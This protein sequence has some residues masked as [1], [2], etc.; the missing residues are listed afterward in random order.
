MLFCCSS[1]KLAQKLTFSLQIALTLTTKLL[2][3]TYLNR[4][5]SSN[6]SLGTGN[7]S[8][9]DGNVEIHSNE[10]SLV[11]NIN[12]IDGQL[13]ETHSQPSHTINNR[14]WNETELFTKRFFDKICPKKQW[15][16]RKNGPENDRTPKNPQKLISI[17]SFRWKLC[18]SHDKHVLHHW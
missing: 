4:W 18:F 16:A 9:L 17:T 8:I 11:L 3:R 15:K 1:K 2:K 12:F 10:D 6:N 13:L 14:F 7:L 5:N